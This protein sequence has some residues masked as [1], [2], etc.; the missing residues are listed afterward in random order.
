MPRVDLDIRRPVVACDLDST[1][2]N[3]QHREHLA[4]PGAL[5]ADVDNWIAYSQACIGDPV[6]A[7]VAELIRI[8]HFAAGYDI[9]FVSGR[10]E[11][12]LPQTI[13]WL[14]KNDIP[15]A[16]IRLHAADDLRHNGEYKAQYIKGLIAEGR[17]VKLMLEDHIE[18]CEVIEELTGVP[19]ITV[20][21]RYDDNVGVSF[22]L[23][24][25]PELFQR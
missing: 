16:E 24:Q 23:S 12:A 17:D 25:H 19:C 15:W 11:E 8:L 18:V 14:E 1:I 10:N 22:N 4:P 5:R 9:H 7:G 6:I 21:P 3:T 20:R 13:E 2:A